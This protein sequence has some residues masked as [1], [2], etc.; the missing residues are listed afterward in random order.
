MLLVNYGPPALGVRNYQVIP[1]E[2]VFDDRNALG[3]AGEACPGDSGG[4][5]FLGPLADSGDKRR[6][7]IAVTS[8]FKGP[9]CRTA[10]AV[11]ARVDNLDVQ[12]WIDWQIAQWLGPQH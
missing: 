1:P 5:T 7:I 2:E 4:A 10:R 12:S 6:T 8:G 3:R 11:T 9:H